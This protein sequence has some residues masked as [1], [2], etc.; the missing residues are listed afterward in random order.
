IRQPSIGYTRDTYVSEY[1]RR[2]ECALNIEAQHSS[3]CPY[4]MYFEH[5]TEPST[6]N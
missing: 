3:M 4:V 5:G 1:R 2:V 6:R